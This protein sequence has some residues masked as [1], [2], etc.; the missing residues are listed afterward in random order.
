MPTS[1]TDGLDWSSIIN[2]ALAVYGIKQG[3][4]TPNFYT[5]PPTPEEAW[6]TDATKSLYSTASGFTDQYLKGLGNLNPDWQM[7]NSTTGNPAFMGG[8]KVPQ[9]DFSKVPSLNGASGASPT[10]QTPAAPGG[11]S[12]SSGSGVPGDPFGHMGAPAGSAGDPFADLPTGTTPD[13]RDGLG[14]AAQWMQQHPDIVKLGTAAVIAAMTAVGGPIGALVGQLG[15]KLINYLMGKV[16]ELPVK[17]PN[18]PQDILKPAGSPPAPPPRTDLNPPGLADPWSG[19][20]MGGGT[21]G[22]TGGLVAGGA[23]PY[24][25]GGAPGKGYM[26]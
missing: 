24:R 7:P 12:G 2:A 4:K 17:N 8:V 14:T 21:G 18:Y 25:L 11:P 26:P 15:S 19:G 23:D 13:Q 22:L 1:T 9:I 5:V 10:P 20:F 16:G 3:Q 6:R